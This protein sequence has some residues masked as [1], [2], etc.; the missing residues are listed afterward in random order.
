VDVA[1][2]EIPNGDDMGIPRCA[3]K[4]SEKNHP[5]KPHP[6]TQNP[7]TLRPEPYALNATPRPPRSAPC[8]DDEGVD[9]AE[10]TTE[11]GFGSVIVVD[12]LPCVPEAKLAKLTTVLGKIFGQIGT[13]REGGLSMPVDKGMTK[14]FAFVEF[15]TPQEAA[16]AREQTDG[17]KLDKAHIF[18]VSKFDDFAKYDA[19]SD[20]Y[21]QPEPKPYSAK[22][23]PKPLN[24]AP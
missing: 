24:L 15:H 19:V 17:Y 8:S 3:E 5:T 18:K 9:E 12:N 10:V 7:K 1:K 4:Q 21:K 23:N 16:A 11:S 2:L 6:D 14:G 20:A 13:V 22:A